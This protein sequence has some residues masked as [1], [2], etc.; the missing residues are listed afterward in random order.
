MRVLSDTCNSMSILPASSQRPMT[1]RQALI[2]TLCVLLGGIPAVIAAHVF[3][4]VPLGTAWLYYAGAAYLSFAVSWSYLDWQT[5]NAAIRGHNAFVIFAVCLIIVVFV[6]QKEHEPFPDWAIVLLIV[7]GIA[8]Y[9][10]A[11]FCGVRNFL[12]WRRGEFSDERPQTQMNA[13][14]HRSN[15]CAPANR[16]HAS[17]CGAVRQLARAFH[18]QPCPPVAARSR[19]IGVAELGCSVTSIPSQ[20][21]ELL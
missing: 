15:K 7:A 13:H 21:K 20:R 12:R 16:R 8:G 10:V 18:T 5:R 3:L 2:I 1:P 9:S 4:Y 17:P 14:R 6:I 11:G 19:F